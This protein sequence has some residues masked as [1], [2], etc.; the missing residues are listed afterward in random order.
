MDEASFADGAYDRSWV[1][2]KAAFL[3]FTV[4]VILRSYTAK[5]FEILPR[6]RI[7]ERTFAWVIR[8]RCLVRD[9]EQC[10]DVAEAMIQIAMGT[11]CRAETLILKFPK[12]PQAFIV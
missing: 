9:Y 3:D 1:M 7:V 8:C 2:D 5:G 4:E 12:N 6:R 10:I 11:S